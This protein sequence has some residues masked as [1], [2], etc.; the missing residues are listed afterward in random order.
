MGAFVQS[1]SF[2]SVH[3]ALLGRNVELAS[4]LLPTS[5]RRAL[6]RFLLLVLATAAVGRPTSARARVRAVAAKP[7]FNAPDLAHIRQ[8][9]GPVRC[10]N[11]FWMEVVR[12]VGLK[13]DVLRSA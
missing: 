10:R 4:G 7:D 2:E 8:I 5:L 12:L 11:L 1:T 9:L 13:L 3:K 6:V